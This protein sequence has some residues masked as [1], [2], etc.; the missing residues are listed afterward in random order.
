MSVG[1]LVSQPKFKQGGCRALIGIS[2]LMSGL[3]MMFLFIAVA[4]MYYV[5]VERDNIKEIA[6]AYKDT[7]VAIYNDLVNEF[8]ADLPVGMR[9][10]ARHPGG[11]FQQSRGA[12]PFWLA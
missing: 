5:Q 8:K 7:Q 4:Y 12:V 3:M 10:S 2:D 9:L 6:V 1:Q 11:D